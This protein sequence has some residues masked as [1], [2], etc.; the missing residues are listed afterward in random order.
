ML[1]AFALRNVAGPAQALREMRRVVVPGGQ[2]LCVELSRPEMPGFRACNL[3]SRQ[4]PVR[5]SRSVVH[6]LAVVGLIPAA[7]HSG[8]A[9][10]ACSQGGG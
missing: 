6:R 9:L 1:S 3:V 8:I 10:D 4:R 2:V 7:S 5:V